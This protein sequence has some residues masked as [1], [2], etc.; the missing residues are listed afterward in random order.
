[1]LEIS[2]TDILA[3]TA[4]LKECGIFDKFYAIV[5]VL[6]LH[7]RK[8]GF[9]RMKEPISTRGDRRLPGRRG[10]FNIQVI[11]DMPLAG[12]ACLSCLSTI[13]K[14]VTLIVT[15]ISPGSSVAPF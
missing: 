2:I 3:T 11:V 12:N 6:R 10:W 1:V 15:L 8:Y 13:L 4:D 14:F 5:C 7:L 9:L